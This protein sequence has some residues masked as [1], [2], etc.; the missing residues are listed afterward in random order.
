MDNAIDSQAVIDQADSTI[1]VL[2]MALDGANPPDTGDVHAA[3]AAV[4]ALLA[5]ARQ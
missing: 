4:R 3:L 2:M 5:T 1:S